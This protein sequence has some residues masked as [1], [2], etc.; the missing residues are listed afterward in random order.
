MADTIMKPVSQLITS[1]SPSVTGMA[2]NS[3]DDQASDFLKRLLRIMS[4][5]EDQLDQEHDVGVRLVSFGP[6]AVIHVSALNY[7]NPN[8]VRFYGTLEDGSPVELVQHV[9]QVSFLL[10]AV[11]R[12]NPEQPKQKKF[13]FITLEEDKECAGETA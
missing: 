11:R 10:V 5:F 6:A 13:G 12:Q 4:D 1:I 8:L 3:E 2:A 9:S 7:F